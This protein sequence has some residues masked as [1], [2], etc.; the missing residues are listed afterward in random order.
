MVSTMGI[1]TADQRISLFCVGAGLA[2]ISGFL[3]WLSF[4]MLTMKMNPDVDYWATVRDRA[5]SN[6]SLTIQFGLCCLV[7]LVGVVLMLQAV[8]CKPRK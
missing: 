7:V 5:Q 6:P 2:L 1:S 3:A 8:F 4:F